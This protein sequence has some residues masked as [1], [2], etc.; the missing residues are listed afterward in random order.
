MVDVLIIDKDTNFLKNL[1]EE[2]YLY[3][4]R[5]NMITASSKKKAIDILRTIMVDV[6]II[7]EDMLGN[8]DLG[9][10]QQLRKL[11]NS[12]PCIQ[13][14][15]MSTY[16]RTFSDEQLTGLRFMRLRKEAVDINNAARVSRT[17]E[18]EIRLHHGLFRDKQ[19]GGKT[20]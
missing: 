15:L 1:H 19:Y 12:Y 3:L 10:M 14:I 4:D 7:D 8:D 11:Q 13:I 16:N 20:I 5:F 18:R 6:V 17:V 2:L 9:L